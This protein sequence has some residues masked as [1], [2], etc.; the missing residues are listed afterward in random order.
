[1]HDATL[2][3]AASTVIT[4]SYTDNSGNTT[5][6]T[7]NVVIEDATAPVPDLTELPDITAACEVTVLN[8]P[9]ATD[10]CLGT[11]DGV[12]DASLPILV[13][14]TTVITWSYTDNNGN[15][16]TQIQNIV[17]E[18]V[19]T[20]EISV[21][22]AV[23]IDLQEGENAAIIENDEFDA[24]ATDNCGIEALSNNFNNDT[25]L[26]N[27]SFAPGVHNVIWTATDVNGNEI[28]D[29]TVITVNA[30]IGIAPS[31]EN[32]IVI[33]PNPSKGQVS[34]ANATGY[35]VKIMDMAGRLV[36]EKAISTNNYLVDL[37]NGIYVIQLTSNKETQS[38]VLIVE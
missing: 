28:T 18:D 3:I 23:T 34:I 9:T 25:T 33:Y 21:V 22:D 26:A 38:S 27:E 30:Y 12:H 6:Q 7:Q 20:P 11:I 2:P 10:N 29:T 24:T 37:R 17:I 15:I 36:K 13:Q 31:T 35:N 4:W 8:T 5:T 1:M 19:T 16:A 32:G 14:G